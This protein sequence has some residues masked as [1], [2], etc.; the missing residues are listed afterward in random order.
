MNDLE[1]VA[2]LL[3]DNPTSENRELEPRDYLYASEL[4]K[5]DIDCYLAMHAVPYS[6]PPSIR[7]RGKFSAGNLWEGIIQNSFRRIGLLVEL[8]PDEKRVRG[9]MPG[10][11]PVSGKIDIL[12]DGQKT[13]ADLKRVK[14]ET[15]RRLE[16]MIYDDPYFE[17]ELKV[18]IRIIDGFLEQKRTI[19]F[20]N[21]I[22]EVKSSSLMSFNRIVEL[23]E[24]HE[25]HG[26]QAGFYTRFNKNWN[27]KTGI[28]LYV[29]KDDSRYHLL[30]ID[31]KKNS[32]WQKKLLESWKRK[33]ENYLK[34]TPPEMEP[35]IAEEN[36]RF[37]LNFNVMYSNYLTMIY[38]FEHQEEYREAYSGKIASW[39]RVLKRMADEEKIT[40]SNLEYIEE[41]RAAGYEP[42]KMAFQLQQIINS[43][44]EGEIL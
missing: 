41:M 35:L 34:E 30:E 9:E 31:G 2:Q 33:S 8:T 13:P 43:K 14:A 40:K 28:I 42:E 12:L 32:K 11:V 18:T 24:P 7:A 44:K 19:S 22:I 1:T 25:G 15:Q 23:N 29:C 6:N 21:Q 4:G 27:Q 20:F 5:S 10:Y 26:L 16:Q 39:N 38:G 3:N 17:E 37:S 36:G